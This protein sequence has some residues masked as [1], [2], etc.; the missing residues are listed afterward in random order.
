M[1]YSAQRTREIDHVIRVNF[2]RCGR[3][4]GG[5][6]KYLQTLCRIENDSRIFLTTFIP[7]TR[8]TVS[9]AKNLITA[10]F[11]NDD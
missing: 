4:R 2:S 11:N 10:R 9:Y 5:R 3:G 8:D 6:N 7:F 1:L